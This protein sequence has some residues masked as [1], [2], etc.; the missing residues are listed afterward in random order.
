MNFKK[1]IKSFLYLIIFSLVF[2][3]SANNVIAQ[4]E[5]GEQCSQ[6]SECKTN[7]CFGAPG[8]KNYCICN[9]SSDCKNR[10]GSGNWECQK[11][12]A[13]MSYC[14][15]NDSQVKVYP[16]QE[17]RKGIGAEC[18]ENWECQTNT[19]ESGYCVC[20][21]AD[22]CSF[23]YGE[24]DWECQ[25][26]NVYYANYCYDNDSGNTEYASETEPKKPNPLEG[27][28]EQKA[29]KEESNA[30]GATVKEVELEESEIEEIM[31][32]PSLQEQIPG[33]NFADKTDIPII[34]KG[35]DRYL[36]IPYL[37]EYI[38]AVYKWSIAAA[39]ILA[40]IVIIVSG[41]QWMFPALNLFTEGE[42][43][44]KK[45][46]N[47]AKKRIWRSVSGL[48]IVLASYTLL[49]TIN[50]ELVEFDALQVKYIEKQEI[51]PQSD[52][53]YEPTSGN[54]FQG[55]KGQKPQNMDEL[56]KCIYN[57]FLQGKKLGE[58][59]DFEK[60][61]FWGLN[62][63]VRVNKN[64]AKS[65]KNVIKEIENSGNKKV[66]GYLNFMKDYTNKKVPDLSGN[67][68]GDN[69]YG[70]ISQQRSSGIGVGN[71]GEK[72]SRI[73][74]GMH[75]LGLAVDI[76]TRSNW[77][78]SLSSYGG[79][80]DSVKTWCKKYV[81]NAKD[82]RKKCENGDYDCRDYK[83]VL[84]DVIDRLE[85]RCDNIDE[86]FK[87]R[88]VVSFPKEWVQIF[89]RNGFYWGGCGWGND[90]RS[91]GMHFEYYGS[92]CL[93]IRKKMDDNLPNCY[94]DIY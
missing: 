39:G 37:G 46:I 79:R 22:D 35:G 2:L 65:W 70:H 59:P 36:V 4:K 75:G 58:Q 66:Q 23:R 31:A 49:Y 72:L 17:E 27:S 92:E 38:S 57:N 77:D 67:Y 48:V 63:S 52:G 47:Q 12:G 18:S 24:S 76:M 90:P 94:T 9:S 83:G 33:L 78:V 51:V 40:V 50:P 32:K 21:N 43:N 45:T 55:S 62:K 73:R 25:T 53:G 80:G 89:K 14:Y 28:Q 93:N 19:C 74:G 6:N 5:I 69:G 87:A 26:G 81:R 60:I 71:D 13:Y 44:Q 15:D 56:D 16:N 20:A 30:E 29:Y 85:G 34:E 88:N 42:G 91:D 82:I 61:N 8:S 84:K 1:Y 64:S 10:Y 7:Q 3:L 54:P 68:Y 86:N 41:I 11:S